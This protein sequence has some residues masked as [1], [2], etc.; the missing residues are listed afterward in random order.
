MIRFFLIALGSVALVLLVLMAS[1]FALA[2]RWWSEDEP[3]P[4]VQQEPL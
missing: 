3:A 1:A 2:V 4:D